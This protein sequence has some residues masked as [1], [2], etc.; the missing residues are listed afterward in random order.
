MALTAQDHGDLG[1]RQAGILNHRLVA[2]PA[3]RRGPAA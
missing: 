1:S 3:L 2:G